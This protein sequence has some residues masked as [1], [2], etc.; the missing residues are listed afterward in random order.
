MVRE[1]GYVKVLDFGLARLAPLPAVAGTHRPATSPDQPDARH[2]ALHVAGAGARRDRDRAPATCSRSA[3]CSTSW[4]RP[5][6]RSSRTSTLGDA[7][8]HHLDGRAESPC[9]WCRTCR[10]RSSGC[11][12]GC[13]RRRPRRG[14]RAA[15]VEAELTRLAAG[16]SEP[17]DARAGPGRTVRRSVA[18][19]NLPSQ[20]TALDR[21]GRRARQRQG[22][23]ARRRRPADDADGPGRHRQ[24]AAGHP[25]RPK[26]SSLTSRAACRSST[27]RRLPIRGWWHPPSPG[28]SACARAAISRSM[29]AIAEHLRSLGPT[30]LL[31]DN[32]EQVSDAA[33]LVQGA[34]GRLSRRSRCW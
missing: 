34:A 17:A 12:S 28:R 27:S 15:E 14:R 8:R 10:R 32:F 30:L 26:T 7:P 22:H 29:K 3:W 1:D 20:R 2:A 18:T 31:M 6:T 5:R 4:R 24:D 16:L 25:G 23:A 19:H 13:S 9:S 11:S 21:A 33:A